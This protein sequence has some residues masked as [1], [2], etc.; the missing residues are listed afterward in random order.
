MPKRKHTEINLEQ[1]YKALL[2]LDKGKSRKFYFARTSLGKSNKDVALSFGIP[3]NTL[4]NLKKRKERIF[5]AYRNGKAKTKRVKSD[6]YEKVNSAVLR[7][8]KR[9]R[10]E[11]VPVSRILLKE[12]ALFFAKEFNC[13]SFH[14]SDFQSV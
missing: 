3:P 10:A 8:F 2:E 9:T 6:T 4:S 12:K 14:A 1:K 7:W 11:N 13:E 5:E